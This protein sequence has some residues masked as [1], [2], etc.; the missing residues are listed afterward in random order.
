MTGRLK[1]LSPR[2]V[3]ILCNFFRIRPSLEIQAKRI[4][5]DCPR[6]TTEGKMCRYFAQNRRAGQFM[7]P[8]V[9]RK[10]STLSRTG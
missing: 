7:D 3:A 2:L 10:G 5:R 1:L 6:F 9:K 4:E 8:F